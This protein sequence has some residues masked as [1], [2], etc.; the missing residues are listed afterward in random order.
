MREKGILFSADMVR[1]L[2]AGRKTCTCIV[3]K[4]FPCIGYKW[5]GWIT[6][7]TEGKEIGNAVIVPE[8]Q[9]IYD[10]T[11]A[12]YAKPPVAVG[13]RIYVRETWQE[14]YDR[15]TDVWKP[16]YYA[17]NENKI[18]IDDDG[19][20]KW[21]PSV[22]MPKKYARIWLD[23]TDV[24]VSCLNDVDNTEAEKEGF[25]D[26]GCFLKYMI[27]KYVKKCTD[28]TINEL[29]HTWVWVITFDKK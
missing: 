17:G 10:H 11:N 3:I 9:E 12:I 8:S 15:N 27:T 19:K 28:E 16:L 25:A 7:S 14:T 23:V 22:R 26:A 24:H 18:W 13:D 20:M 4:K 21:H 5:A 6:D 1:A 29:L 2:Q